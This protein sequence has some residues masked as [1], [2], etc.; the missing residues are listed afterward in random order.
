M[1]DRRY[2][3]LNADVDSSLL[4]PSFLR[5]VVF[6]LLTESK[7]LVGRV[8]TNWATPACCLGAASIAMSAWSSEQRLAPMALLLFLPMLIYRAENRLGAF[9]VAASYYG[10][11]TRAVPG[12]IAGFFPGWPLGANWAVWAAHSVLLALPWALTYQSR[13]KT[14]LRRV[15]G[16]LAALILLSVP[17]LGLFHWGSPLMVAGLF[18]P[19]WRGWGLL[20]TLALLALVATCTRRSI[21]RQVGIA[22]LALSAY[23]ANLAFHAPS[24]PGGWLALSLRLGKSPEL[25]S[26]DM[27]VRRK[28]LA[29]TARFALEE[30]NIVVVL[31]E[32]ISG[33]SRRSQTDI[34]RGVAEYAR[35]L[36]ATVL[37]GE[38]VWNQENTNFRNALVG[39]GDGGNGSVIVSSQV[40]MPIG[41]WKFGYDGGAQTNLL[42]RDVVRLH[43][44]RV[45]FSMCYEDFIL[46]PHRGLLSG[47]ADLL[48]SAANQWPSRGTSA[49]IAQDVSRHALARLAGVP[50]LTAKNH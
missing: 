7:P 13:G 36:G 4:G 24:T 27:L 19:A 32:S 28:F 48:V 41:D 42:G 15:L 12:I 46:W 29:E 9:F 44:Q 17:P 1:A 38:E 18:F 16:V 43:G 11:A 5:R 3:D 40:P 22:V 20:A 8:C 37:V 10:M 50:L 6:A 49:E 45:A 31:P 26:D 39:Y 23:L 25:W 30:G 2:D 35:S 34:W 33:S 14:P 47:N 21:P